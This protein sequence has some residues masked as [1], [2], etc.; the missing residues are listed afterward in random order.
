MKCSKCGKTLKKDGRGRSRCYNCEYKEDHKS[1]KSKAD[2]NGRNVARGRLNKW[3]AS[4]GK[5]VPANKDVHH[6]DG[7]PQNN[8][9]GNTRLIDESTN[10]GISNKT[11]TA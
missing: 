2:R 8:S 10:R 11:R 3:Y 5:K 7:N 1:K 9:D 4:R 6:V